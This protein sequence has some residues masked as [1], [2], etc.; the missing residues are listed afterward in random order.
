M[1]LFHLFQTG[2]VHH[3]FTLTAQK[4]LRGHD[5]KLTLPHCCTRIRHNFFTLRVISTWNALPEEIVH[6]HSK[7]TFKR[8]LDSYLGL[9]TFTFFIFSFLNFPH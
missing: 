5:M 6:S 8:L 3:F 2:D 1:L 7:T 9:K 4:H